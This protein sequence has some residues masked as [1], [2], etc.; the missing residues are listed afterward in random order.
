VF[1][2]RNRDGCA[3]LGEDLR[4][5]ASDPSRTTCHDRDPAL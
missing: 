4:D 1:S 2:R 5:A 3:L